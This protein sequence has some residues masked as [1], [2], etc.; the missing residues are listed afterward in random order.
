M[1]FL[2][3]TR[4]MLGTLKRSLGET[5]T[6]KH[7]G[8]GSV[9]ITAV[10]NREHQTVDPDTE[11]I[12]SSNNPHIG[13]QLSDLLKP[14]K[15]DDQVVFQGDTYRVVDVEEDGQGA[16]QIVLFKT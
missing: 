12:V 3:K 5:M 13:V 2:G 14:P 7:K 4:L 8:G 1:S 10:W 6:Y 16:A 9:N 11:V 15:D